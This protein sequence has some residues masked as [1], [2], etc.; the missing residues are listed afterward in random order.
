[1]LA[2]AQALGIM[3]E[4][5]PNVQC[6]RLVR[7]FKHPDGVLVDTRKVGIL[8]EY[9]E[10]FN[11]REV[12]WDTAG[13]ARGGS[14]WLEN[15]VLPWTRSLQQ[16][17]Q[18]MH[19]S[20]VSHRDLKPGNVVLGAGGN[21]YLIDFGAASWAGNEPYGSQGEV[22]KSRCLEVI[23]SHWRNHPASYMDRWYSLETLCSVKLALQQ[24]RYEVAK[25]DAEVR[26]YVMPVQ[27]GT[28]A[29]RGQRLLK[30]MTSMAEAWEAGKDTGTAQE[31][32]KLEWEKKIATLTKDVKARVKVWKDTKKALLDTTKMLCGEAASLCHRSP[33]CTRAV[34][35]MACH[36]AS[37]GDIRQGMSEQ[38]WSQSSDMYGVGLLVLGW[39]VQKSMRQIAEKHI[40]K[41]RWQQKPEAEGPCLYKNGPSGPNALGE[42]NA[43]HHWVET[44]IIKEE[45]LLKIVETLRKVGDLPDLPVIARGKGQAASKNMRATWKQLALL[46]KGLLAP[47]QAERWTASFARGFMHRAS[48]G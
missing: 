30:H 13:E 24:A 19:A 18:D 44:F 22:F 45:K 3:E 36:G 11:L 34:F 29:H 28:S 40:E 26:K 32:D 33:E 38:V 5:A 25:L 7:T 15:Q 12:E 47:R 31:N 1:M 20:R 17:V 6:P 21:V 46:L 27:G 2:E 41:L 4:L 16:S 9:K 42:D 43:L 37:R 10:A 35:E 23:N 8:M 48:T 14:A 39:I